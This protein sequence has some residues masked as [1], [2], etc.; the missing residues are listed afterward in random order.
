MDASSNFEPVRFWGVHVPLTD[1]TADIFFDK[2]VFEPELLSTLLS[3]PTLAYNL[4][5]ANQRVITG[6]ME[7]SR[8][9]NTIDEWHYILPSQS[10]NGFNFELPA[11]YLVSLDEGSQYQDLITYRVWDLNEILV[12]NSLDELYQS[13]WLKIFLPTSSPVIIRPPA[14]YSYVSIEIGG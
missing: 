14:V 4:N 8:P 12:L 7:V 10:D 2:P 6:Y 3:N 9:D 13:D 5:G 11:D 1:D